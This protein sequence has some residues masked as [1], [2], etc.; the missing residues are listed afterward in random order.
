MESINKIPQ[1]FVERSNVRGFLVIIRDWGIIFGVMSFS[2]W[3]ENIFVYISSIILIGCMQFAISES[4]MHEATHGNLF[5]R[6]SWNRK[7]EFLFS[8][9]CLMTMKEYVPDHLD[10]HNLHGY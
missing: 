9:P 7:L 1:D 8:L 4:L 6:E 10:H 2:I 3:A 5:K